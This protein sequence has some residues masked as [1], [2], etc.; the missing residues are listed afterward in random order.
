MTIW[1]TTFTTEPNT[2]TAPSVDSGFASLEQVRAAMGEPFREGPAG[3]V[4]W[5][6]YGDASERVL[7]S[8][9]RWAN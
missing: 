5:L 9:L 7:F 2:V 1:C 4:G 6:V 8:R 3:G